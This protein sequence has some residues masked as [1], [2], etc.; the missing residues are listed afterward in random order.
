MGS[1]LQ[2]SFSELLP[3]TPIPAQEIGSSALPAEDQGRSQSASAPW[4]LLVW[5]VEVG[6]DFTMPDRQS[7]TVLQKINYHENLIGIGS[8]F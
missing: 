2:M 8:S 4:S 7:S 5:R 6:G 1:R 3:F